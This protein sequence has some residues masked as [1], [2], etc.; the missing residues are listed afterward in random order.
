MKSLT[1]VNFDTFTW[2]RPKGKDDKFHR[3][4]EIDFLSMADGCGYKEYA[5]KDN[6]LFSALAAL[7]NDR[8]KILRFAQQ[9]RLPI[10][11]PW[12]FPIQKMP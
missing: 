7:G 12:R 8:C 3:S 9:G 1:E 2:H 5:P 11:A 6:K 4:D 10:H